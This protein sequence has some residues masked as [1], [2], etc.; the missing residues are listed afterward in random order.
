MQEQN[1]NLKVLKTLCDVFGPTSYE[2]NVL[3]SIQEILGD[4]FYHHITP[5]KNLIVFNPSDKN[6]S[7]K[8]IVLQSHMDELGIKPRAYLDNGLIEVLPISF[9]S[10]DFHDQKV[11]FNPGNI[12]GVLLLQKAEKNKKYFVDIGISNKEDVMK[13]VP[14]YS[15]GAA[16]N[17]V[18]FKEDKVFGKSFDARA[19]VASIVSVLKSKNIF[20]NTNN[21]IVAV[22]SAREESSFWP[23]SEI[24]SVFKKENIKPS[25]LINIEVCPGN[26]GPFTSPT[27]AVTGKG[28][29]IAHMDASYVSSSSVSRSIIEIGQECNIP[30]QNMVSS[31]GH[32]ELGKLCF[33][34]ETEGIGFALPSLAMHSPNSIIS[35]NDYLSL[36]DFLTAIIKEY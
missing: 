15:V 1:Y 29:V 11:V 2:E 7:T 17:K 13:L 26:H 5:H 32:G 34:L 16:Y 4:S 36:I 9:V 27:G 22:F 21:R 23:H 10:D 8:T 12:T 14:V 35:K 30:Y 6:K 28:P 19:G 20:E 3:D 18:E 33:E 25:L 31:A 24:A